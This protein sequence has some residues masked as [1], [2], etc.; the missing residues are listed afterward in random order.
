MKDV[1]VK[2]NLDAL[3]QYYKMFASKETVVS[4]DIS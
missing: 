1:F 4:F 3:L 2:L